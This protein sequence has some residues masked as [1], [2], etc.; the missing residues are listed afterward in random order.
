MRSGQQHWCPLGPLHSEGF[1]AEHDPFGRLRRMVLV[2][3]SVLIAEFVSELQSSSSVDCLESCM[4]MLNSDKSHFSFSPCSFGLVITQATLSL[5]ACFIFPTYRAE[6]KFPTPRVKI[7]TGRLWKESL[8]CL[9]EVCTLCKLSILNCSSRWKI[10]IIDKRTGKGNCSLRYGFEKCGLGLA[11]PF[12][13]FHFLISALASF[14]G[15]ALLPIT[16]Y[17]AVTMWTF[18]WISWRMLCIAAICLTFP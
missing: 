6:A 17:C 9:F 16:I 8:T 12:W 15:L 3:T 18:M 2:L 10:V 11:M 4:Q 5:P 14:L 13:V 1:C 7:E